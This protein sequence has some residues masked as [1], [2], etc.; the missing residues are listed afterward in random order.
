MRILVADGLADEGLRRLRESAEVV[1]RSGMGEEDLARELRDAEA[2]IVRS[3]TRVSAR[4]LEGALRLRVVA[5]AGVGVD[6]IDVD[7]ATRRGILVLN[8]PE[9]STTA[10]AE[11]TMAL[12]LALVRHVPQAHA[13]LTA[14]RW[15]RESF[16]GTEL[17]GTP[18]GIVR[19][20]TLVGAAELGAVKP[21]V[22]LVNCARGGLSDEAAVW[23][24]LKRGHVAGAAHDVI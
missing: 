10:A 15:D 3:G 21:G 23:E 16:V 12:L 24:A 20:R 22:F 1:V 7:A 14:G 6:N 11:H 2:V 8:A 9:A 17:A 4:A 18:L 5:R 19:L 13:S